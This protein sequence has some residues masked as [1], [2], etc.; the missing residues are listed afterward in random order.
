MTSPP[1]PAV[2]LAR[3]LRELREQSWETPLTQRELARV[4]SGSVP[5]ISSWESLRS[6]TVPP[7]ERLLAY[8]AFFATPRSIERSPY[9]ILTNEELTPDERA[10]R[11]GL[12]RELLEARGRA[13]HQLDDPTVHRVPA[14][15]PWDGLG[16]PWQFRDGKPV[17]LVC[18]E[19]P[20]QHTEPLPTPDNPDLFYNSLY[21][22]S[23]LDALME[24]YGHIRAVNPAISVGYRKAN[25]L[26]PDDYTTH[27]VLLGGIQW[28]VATRVL[29]GRSEVPVTQVS[30]PGGRAEYQVKDD[31]GEVV[32]YRA[33]YF[34][35]DLVTDVGHFFRTLNP[36]N[37]R[38]TVT[39]CNGITSRGVLGM[40]RALT[41]ERFWDR[42]G[43]YLKDGFTGWR[44]YSVLT[45][46]RIVDGAVLT[47]DWTDPDTRLHEWRAHPV[48]S[49]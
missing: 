20:R 12:E 43:V 17:T 39:I 48:R 2:A 1:E 4:F 15:G 25:E 45:R 18:S 13:L 41:D 9:R 47:P 31:S 11:D 34:E 38:R 16:G 28:N 19:R 5:L 14:R 26:Q 42:N 30:P 29:L 10:R 36:F 33:D 37:H 3:R 6:P 32:S 24:L 49:R 22:Y 7:A 46:V 27:L 44:S 35:D 40:V 21:S 23:D 8:A